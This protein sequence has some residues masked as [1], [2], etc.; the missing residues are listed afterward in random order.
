M[1][2]SVKKIDNEIWWEQPLL[3]AACLK[4]YWSPMLRFTVWRVV[5]VSRLC[6]TF[7][8]EC[9]VVEVNTL[10]NKHNAS[11][12]ILFIRR[13]EKC[14]TLYVY[15]YIKQIRHS[16]QAC[17][18]VYVLAYAD[19]TKKKNCVEI[20]WVYY[21]IVLNCIE[22][23]CRCVLLVHKLTY[24]CIAC[25]THNKHTYTLYNCTHSQSAMNMCWRGRDILCTM[26]VQQQRHKYDQQ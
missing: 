3:T 8:T 12:E 4:S 15:K 10:W 26:Y 5:V 14:Y 6:R 23:C 7:W 19:R 25:T 20:L 24:T 11:W 1:C 18:F 9:C 21:L 17:L 2:V 13:Y 16:Q 22:R